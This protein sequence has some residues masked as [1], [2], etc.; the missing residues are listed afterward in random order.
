MA[1]IVVAPTYARCCVVGPAGTP[2]GLRE[3]VRLMNDDSSMRPVADVLGDLNEMIW[4]AFPREWLK[5]YDRRRYKGA[6]LAEI[7]RRSLPWMEGGFH[8]SAWMRRD[9]KESLWPARWSWLAVYAVT[10]RRADCGDQTA[11]PPLDGRRVSYVRL[12][13]PRLQGIALAGALELAG[14]I[15]RHRDLR[16]PLRAHRSDRFPWGRPSGAHGHGEDLLRM[17]KG[18]RKSTRLNS[19]H[20]GIS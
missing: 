5:A 4:E 15:R 18:D 19:S 6:R 13:A 14:G 12:D 16:R 17:G 20:L 10:D 8:T 11:Q 1:E 3:T 7:K 9:Y 2:G